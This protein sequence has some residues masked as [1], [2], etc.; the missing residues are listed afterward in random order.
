MNSPLGTLKAHVIGMK[1]RLRRERYMQFSGLE[2]DAVKLLSVKVTL[3]NVAADACRHRNSTAMKVGIKLGNSK[4][5]IDESIA[6]TG[7]PLGI[8]FLKL[9]VDRN[10]QE[11]ARCVEH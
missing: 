9:C 6:I 7:V 5:G 8:Y 2:L 3:P 11:S 10:R 4:G 1:I